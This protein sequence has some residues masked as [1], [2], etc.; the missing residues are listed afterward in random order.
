MKKAINFRHA[1]LH[2]LYMTSYILS[3][4]AN[5]ATIGLMVTNTE[6]DKIWLTQSGTRLMLNHENIRTVEKLV[7]VMFAEM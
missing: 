7:D 3:Y 5:W 4:S 1:Y 2:K 6:D